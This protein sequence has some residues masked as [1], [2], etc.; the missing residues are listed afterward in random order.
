MTTD[1]QH[2]PRLYPGVTVS[3]TFT[4][5]KDHLS[6]VLIKATRTYGMTDVAMRTIRPSSLTSLN[7]HSR[8]FVMARPISASSARNMAD[9]QMP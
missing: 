2:A 1:D 9:T 3:S 7:P 8:W 6:A 5:P 4:D